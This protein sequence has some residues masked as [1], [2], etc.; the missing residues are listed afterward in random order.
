M[1]LTRLKAKLDN[2]PRV[3]KSLFD[4][5]TL[6]VGFGERR[7]SYDKATLVGFARFKDHGIPQV[8]HLYRIR[9]QPQ[10]IRPARARG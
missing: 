10:T 8:S 9:R 5:I 7:D 1:S 4:R 6:C 3:C 2:L